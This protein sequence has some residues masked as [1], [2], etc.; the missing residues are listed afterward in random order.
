MQT[1]ITNKTLICPKCSKEYFHIN[2]FLSHISKTHYLNSE[3]LYC[4]QNNIITKPLCKCGCGKEVDFHT[5]TT[6]YYLYKRGHAVQTTDHLHT[7]EAQEKS[8]QTYRD[9]LASG[10]TI[11]KRKEKPLIDSTKNYKCPL[12]SY[13]YEKLI[14]LSMHFRRL[15]HKT[16]KDLYI[17]LYC[18]NVEPL[19]KCGC[20]EP[21]KFLDTTRGFSE[22][23]WGHA[24][25]IHNNW[26]HNPI[27][28]QKSIVTKQ[29]RAGTGCYTS[30]RKGLT[31]ETDE[32]L[33]ATGAKGSITIQS[34]PEELK[35]RSERYK[36][37]WLSGAFVP[38]Q[39]EKH[40]QW[41]GGVSPLSSLCHSNRKLY[42]EWKYPLLK[43][44]E[45]KC[46]VC[47]DAK[48]LNVHHDQQ[49]FAEILHLVAKE[50]DWPVS[51]REKF[52]ESNP[53]IL[54]L[55]EK[56]PDAVAEYHIKNNI[57]GIVLCIKCHKKLHKNL[58]FKDIDQ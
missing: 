5:Y 7:K 58:N 39:K 34:N 23:Q 1:N 42:T 12:C 24:S 40:S 10:K 19:C 18:N 28:I 20:N 31:K 43:A 33:R 14:S 53:E 8:R 16:A 38:L 25:R 27:A 17:A 51:I 9:N 54:L 32:R 49:T 6:G 56:I 52:I 15:H 36:Q 29:E 30:W 22:Y 46:S 48:E 44:A 37:N 26:G 3:Q 55:K 41:K 45:F 35:R 13:S 21:T 57:H 11:R 50:Y 2:A 47:G 4:E